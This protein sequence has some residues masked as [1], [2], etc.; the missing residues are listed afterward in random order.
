MHRQPFLFNQSVVKID[1]IA[2]ALLYI[3][4]LTIDSAKVHVEQTG[5]TVNIECSA[6]NAILLQVSRLLVIISG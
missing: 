1:L 2:E 5:R 4:A 3:P 6:G